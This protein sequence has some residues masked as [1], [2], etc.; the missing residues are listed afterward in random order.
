MD[1]LDK[2]IREGHFAKKQILSRDRLISWSHR[3]RFEL[4]LQ[5]AR[6]FAGKQI[7]DY[8]CG[9]GSF[10]AMLMNGSAAP[11]AATG[12]EIHPDLVADC[13]ARFGAQ[14]GLS[15]VLDEELET[16]EHQ[17]GFDAVICMEVLEHVV[18]VEPVID[19]FA[20]LLVPAGNLLV[21]VPIETG[22]PLL[23]KQAVRRVAGWRGIGDYPG[24][25]SYSLSELMAGLLASGKR[26]HIARPVHTN[27][28]GSR[29]HDHKGFNWM[30]LRALLARKFHLEKT[31]ASPLT[32]L[33]PHLASQ[34]WFLLQK[35]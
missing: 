11:S 5:L 28:D 7:L 14:H 33:S 23:I 21:S 18:E 25:S 22:P 24:T 20:R 34:V 12:A 17:G 31:Q 30:V 26:Q 1:I 27:T 3:R 10:L 32:W 9:D 29:F 19:R 6:R 15:F 35:K 13:R 4:G 16:P 2:S 8:G